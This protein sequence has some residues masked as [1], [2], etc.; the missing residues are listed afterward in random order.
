MSQDKVNC[1]DV[2]LHICESLGE[3]LHSDRCIAI[4]KH[5]DE[6]SGCQNYFKTVEITIDYYRKYNVAIPEDAHERLMKFL[7]LDDDYG[8]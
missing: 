5:L 1:K 7:D 3:E 8:K 2:M 4:K 6:C